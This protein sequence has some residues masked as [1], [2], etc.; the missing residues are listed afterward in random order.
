MNYLKKGYDYLKG[1]EKEKDGGMSYKFPKAKFESTKWAECIVT[2]ADD[3]K[4]AI[5]KD[6]MSA[7]RN[8][9]R[10]VISLVGPPGVGKSTLASTIYNVLRNNRDEYFEASDGMAGFT[11]GIWTLREQ[12]KVAHNAKDKINI[13][14]LEGLEDEDIIHYFVVVA[15]ALSKA[16]LLCAN[17]NGSPRF[18]FD[19]FNTLQSGIR[20]YK[21]NNIRVPSP[22]IYVQVPFD[23]DTGKAITKFELRKETVDKNGLIRYIKKKFKDLENFEI[24]VFALPTFNKNRFD[25]TYLS[26]VQSLIDELKSIDK[27]IVIEERV[28][29]AKG[30]A[31]ALNN[32]SPSI[33]A[34]MNLKFFRTEIKK[35]TDEIKQSTISKLRDDAK[36]VKIEKMIQY[37]EFCKLVSRNGK[38]RY[39][40]ILQTQAISLAYYDASDG[41]HNKIIRE[42]DDEKKYYLEVKNHCREIYAAEVSSF[43]SKMSA[44][45]Q[46]LM[47][48][49]DTAFKSFLDL[50]IERAASEIKFNGYTSMPYSLR[51]SAQEKSRQLKS[52]V[53]EKTQNIVTVP[54]DYLS[55]DLLTKK[56][57]TKVND[58][59]SGWEKQKKRAL[60]E[61]RKVITSGNHKCPK[62][63]KDHSPGVCHKSCKKSAGGKGTLY[64]WV[65]GPTNT[66]I[67]DKCEETSRIT[68]V[69]CY[70]CSTTL[71]ARIVPI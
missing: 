33:I 38:Y 30:V 15:M 50:E 32:N 52:E 43:K 57:D 46:E 11:K 1:D 45:G 59:K 12:I 55:M 56:W 68:S 23:A 60:V 13:L 6:A 3:D 31:A 9:F 17:Y 4:L 54:S 27:G 2:E 51:S 69:C 22:I 62:C 53:I 47:T 24:R 21:Q 16:M 36:L 71:S 64:Y 61:R 18:K 63:G 29:Y 14:D 40:N 7:V 70:D 19:M 48:L 58:L 41:Q 44:K 25:R 5:N 49:N 34:D 10:D 26:A 8:H 42:F 65:D 67:C 37:T 66:C 20:V 39:G 35:H 28:N